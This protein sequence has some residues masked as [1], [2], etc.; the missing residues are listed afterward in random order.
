VEQHVPHS[1]ALHSS[2]RE[3]GSYLVGP[4][5]RYALNSD[6]LSPLAL[7]AAREAGLS[8]VCRNPFRSI[9]VRAVEILYAFDEAIRIIEGYEEPD[10]PAVEVAPRAGT[11][12]G[13]TE[14]PRGMLWHRYTLDRDGVVADARIVPPT[15][16]NQRVIE[17]DLRALVQRD[18]SLPDEPLRLRCEQAIRNYDPCISC[19]THF[20]TLDVDRA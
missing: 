7:E 8:S 9:I 17:E 18:M 2:L 19:A 1:N 15:S 12:F 13:W 5:A 16:Q 14:A 6:R 10:R 20:L 11:G 3:R 4:L